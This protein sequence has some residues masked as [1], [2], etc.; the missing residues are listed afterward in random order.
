MMTHWNE[1]HDE[2][3]N[4]LS[5]AFEKTYLS[6]GKIAESVKLKEEVI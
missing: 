2:S 5:E 1:Y 3:I 6:D 4:I